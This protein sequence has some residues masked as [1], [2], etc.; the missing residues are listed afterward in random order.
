[1]DHPSLNPDALKYALQ[2]SDAAILKETDLTDEVLSQLNAYKR[3]AGLTAA[4][5]YF[6]EKIP[7]GFN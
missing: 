4:D 6:N 7:F 2:G 5:F 3:K 1:M